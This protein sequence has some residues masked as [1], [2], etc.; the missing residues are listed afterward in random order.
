MSLGLE[1]LKTVQVLDERL[2]I[3]RERTYAILSG[4][5]DNSYKPNVSTSYSTSQFSFSA[6]PPNPAIGVSRKVFLKARVQFDMAGT[7]SG[8]LINYGVTTSLRSFPLSSVMSTAKVTINNT[9]ADINMSDVIQPLM[10]YG[11]LDSVRDE[12][13]IG[14]SMMDAWQDYTS[15]LGFVNNSLGSYGDNTYQQTN[16]IP[17]VSLSQSSTAATLIVDIC[18]PI[19]LSPLYFGKGNAS[20][21]IGVQTFDAT[22]NLNSA[23][24]SR[25]LA[26][27]AVN[28]NTISSVTVSF[29][30]APSL[31]FNYVSPNETVTPVSNVKGYVYPYYV[32]DRYPTSAFSLAAAASSTVN[33]NNIQLNS[34]PKA[35]L[36]HARRSNDTQTMFT[37]DTFAA[38][39]SVSVDWNNRQG[40]LSSA[41][42]QDLYN[43]SRDNGLNMSW[44]A[45]SQNVGGVLKLNFGKDIPCSP[46]ESPGL[47]Q[48]S[49]LQ[50]TANFTNKSLST[51]SYVMYIIVISEGTWTIT[52]NRSVAEIAVV[53]RDDILN[54]KQSP[55]LNYAMYQKG[56]YGGSF[57]GSIGSF[58]RNAGNKA[59]DLIK[60]H[61]PS[62]AVAGVKRLAGLGLSGGRR[63]RRHATGAPRR[64]RGR[65]FEEDE[66]ETDQLIEE[67][68][69]S[70]YSDEP[71]TQ[72]ISRSQLGKVLRKR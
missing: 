29:P 60:E 55:M 30:T 56:I 40:L 1:R 38:I 21:L 69:Y 66:L 8:N 37:T 51:V 10:R 44:T 24:L 65:G 45:W 49:Q 63:R 7:G 27:D 31:L 13:A 16:A 28:G 42:S 61:G 22:F 70:E 6:P 36:V 4:P 34:I 11:H 64:L 33:S 48:T 2:N 52:A 71:A 12:Y 47:L 35:I 3:D 20:M 25:M 57:F 62:L 58:L 46:I 26:H 18:E 50:V 14:P 39:N 15:G 59:V 32:V 23:L 67:D 19:F 53:S 68:E 17:Y 41:S 43:L 72:T 9:S 54:A 5:V